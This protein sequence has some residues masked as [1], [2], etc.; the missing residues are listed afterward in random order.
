MQRHGSRG[1]EPV[2]DLE[3]LC[4]LQRPVDQG[5]R[6]QPVLGSP[7]S[8]PRMQKCFKLDIEDVSCRLDETFHLEGCMTRFAAR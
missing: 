1:G 7:K 5:D 6:S 3:H 8:S 4:A 2:Y